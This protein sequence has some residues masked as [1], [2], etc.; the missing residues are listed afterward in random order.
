[1]WRAY[2][3]PRFRKS[4]WLY[5]ILVLM[6]SHRHSASSFIV[7]S[8]RSEEIPPFRKATVISQRSEEI[9]TFWKQKISHFASLRSKRRC[10]W[11]V[12]SPLLDRHFVAQRRNLIV[13][14]EKDFSLRFAPFEKTML[15]RCHSPLLD[16]HFA[17]QR[18][19]L[20]L[21]EKRRF[22]TPLRS[23]QNDGKKE[24]RSKWWNEKLFS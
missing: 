16:R 18:R 7:I 12:V 9:L 20:I 23:V 8:Q 17:E 13:P 3:Q 4:Y 10:Y 19:N 15:L 6:F 21:L 14:K 24:L 1:M 22:F 11:G 2:R 5:L